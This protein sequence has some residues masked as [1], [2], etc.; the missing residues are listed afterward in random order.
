MEVKRRRRNRKTM[1][2]DVA[3]TGLEDDEDAGL[4]REISENEGRASDCVIIFH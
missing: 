1:Q 2:L 3:Q 4:N